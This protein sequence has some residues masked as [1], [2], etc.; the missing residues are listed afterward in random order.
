MTLMK[1]EMLATVHA[2]VDPVLTARL[3]L[4]PAPD[5]LKVVVETVN[6]HAAG[7]AGSGAVGVSLFEHAITAIDNSSTKQNSFLTE[8]P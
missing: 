1:G 6:V 3:A 4:A 5:R 7:G 2:Q 8:P